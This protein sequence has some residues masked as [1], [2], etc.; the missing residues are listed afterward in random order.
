[1]CQLTQLR[2]FLQ[3]R[4]YISKHH[5]VHFKYNTILFVNYTSVKLEKKQRKIWLP[6]LVRRSKFCVVKKGLAQFTVPE[7]LTH[8]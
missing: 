4:E 3:L 6:S 5:V 2:E 7:L 8:C 1:M